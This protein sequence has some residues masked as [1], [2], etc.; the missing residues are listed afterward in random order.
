MTDQSINDGKTVGTPREGLDM[1]GI[2]RYQ[3][4]LPTK[5]KLKGVSIE[6][7]NKV[8]KN[9]ERLRSQPQI[10]KVESIIIFFS[11]SKQR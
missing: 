1:M 3:R 11:P 10:E 2:R 9:D 5:N 4:S 6:R 8:E 7:P